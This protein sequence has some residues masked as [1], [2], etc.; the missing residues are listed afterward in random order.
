MAV[1]EQLFSAVAFIENF[2]TLLNKKA[3]LGSIGNLLGT[4]QSS[5]WW[6]MMNHMSGFES[7]LYRK[8]SSTCFSVLYF[9]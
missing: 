5:K 4:M 9:S 7:V 6:K 2:I 1:A 8:S 3:S